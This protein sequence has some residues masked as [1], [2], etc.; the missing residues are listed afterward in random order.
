MTDMRPEA[1]LLD[2]RAI[3]SIGLLGIGS[4]GAGWAATFLAHGYRVLAYDPAPNAQDK[5][6]GFLRESW[7]AIRKL[8]VTRE[9]HPPLDRLEFTSLRDL[10]LTSDVVHENAPE[11]LDLKRALL[12]DLAEVSSPHVVI[13]SSS[14]GIPPSQL[15][16]DMPGG[17]R[18]VVAHPFNPPH[19]MPLV[20]VIGGVD[21]APEVVDWTMSY[22]QNVG[23]HPIRL[24]R[25][26]TAYLTN[27]LQ[28][29]LLREAVNCLMEGVASPKSI[30]DAVKYAL[31]PRWAV[32]GG[33]MT[34]ALAG[35]EGG[36]AQV[37]TSFAP[38]IEQWWADLGQPRLTAE[39]QKRL[40]AAADELAEGRPIADWIRT[41]DEQLVKLFTAVG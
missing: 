26:K 15:Q 8:G 2:L 33:L 24:H 35:G 34:L 1:K 3:K 5:A 18:I 9:E 22:L 7:P 38:A 27:R 12:R 36:M 30:D 37:M 40:I 13:C 14:G 6:I 23:K 21:T 31:A 11:L 29:A 20:E 39:V 28:F 19:L 10:A 16:A 32:M 41:R 17:A 4:V 25:E